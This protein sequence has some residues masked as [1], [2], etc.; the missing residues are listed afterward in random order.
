MPR[1]GRLN[2]DD[3]WLVSL[4]PHQLDED[5]ES[6]Y[7]KGCNSVSVV[8]CSSKSLA[9][10]YWPDAFSNGDKK[11]LTSMESEDSATTSP[12]NEEKRITRRLSGWTGATGMRL[13][14]SFAFY[15]LA[16]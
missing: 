3:T 11:A 12:L 7:I 8:M 13:Q 10:V 16:S 4:V 6:S 9:V 5:V 1:L 2:K 15:L 14:A